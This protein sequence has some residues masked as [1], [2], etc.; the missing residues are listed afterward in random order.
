METASYEGLWPESKEHVV[1]SVVSFELLGNRKEQQDAHGHK[2]VIMKD[3]SVGL[4][5]VADGHG[6][7]GSRLAREAVEALLQ[8]ETSFADDRTFLL[9]QFEH[10]SGRLSKET[11]GTTASMAI[12]RKDHVTIGYLGDSEVRLVKK[13]GHLQTLTIPHQY[14]IHGGETERLDE[15][16]AEIYGTAIHEDGRIKK[17]V[18]VSGSRYLEPTR[19]FGDKLF[20]GKALSEPEIIEVTIDAQD[21]F[22]VLATDGLWKKLSDSS[23][24]KKIE[25]ILASASDAQDA[26]QQILA[27]LQQWELSDNTTVMIVEL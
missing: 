26:R 5:A 24:R 13:D 11:S 17:G 10:A 7:D 22:L 18:I 23:K 9:S 21:R 3:A 19:V 20:A 6:K 25:R 16:G 2:I 15:A 4:Y 8:I 27:Q 12:R 1:H 14:G